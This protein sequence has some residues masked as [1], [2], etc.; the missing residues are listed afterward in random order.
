MLPTIR[1]VYELLTPK[2]RWHAVGLFGLMLLV[3]LFQLAAVTSIMPFMAVVADPE[4][5][6][7]NEALVWLGDLAGLDGS[8]FL[9][10]LGCLVLTAVILSNAVAAVGLWANDR[11]VWSVTAS[12]SR[13]LLKK[14]LNRSYLWFVRHGSADA[15]KNILSEVESFSGGF[16][17]SF[18]LLLAKGLTVI[19]LLTVII[20]VDWKIALI[21]ATFLGITYTAI[22]WVLRRRLLA[23]GEKCYEMNRLRFKAV[24]EA[25]GAFQE[26]KVFQREQFFVDAYERPTTRLSRLSVY[27][28]LVRGLPRH[29]LEILAFG[30]LVLLILYFLSTTSDFQSLVPILSLYAFAGYRLLPALQQCFSCV[31]SLRFNEYLVSELHRDFYEVGEEMA[32]ALPDSGGAGGDILPMRR[33]IRF[34]DVSFAYSNEGDKWAVEAVNLTIPSRAMVAFCGATGSGKTTLVNLLL[35][36]YLPRRGRIVIDESPLTGK[37]V[38]AWRR[39][40]GYVPQH[41]FLMDDTIARNIAFGLPDAQI[42]QLA[43]ERAARAAQIH[44]FVTEE[45]AHGYDTVVGERGMRLSG[46]QRQR[47]GIARAIYHDPDVLILDEAT[48]ALDEFTEELVVRGI[49][50]AAGAKTVILIAHRLSAVRGCDR[51]FVVEGGRVVEQGRYGDLVNLDGPFSMMVNAR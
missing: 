14:Y 25:F 46:G 1:K 37:N 24:Q 16:L 23:I 35:G 51:I 33:E 4:V 3:S 32:G 8:G 42:D 22:Y 6:R 18:L 40:V 13:D 50:D 21:A 27:F 43:V 31:A 38:A 12:L 7:R 2:R 49:Q 39:N 19:G 41:I 11:F 48:S 28:A 10:L 47:V 29:L 26:T 20:L 34:E 17:H 9:I 30:G 15:G 44:D 45:L 5:A 36:L